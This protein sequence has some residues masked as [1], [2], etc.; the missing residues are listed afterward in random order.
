[1]SFPRLWRR[2]H[3]E[4][5]FFVVKPAWVGAAGAVLLAFTILRNL[6]FARAHGLT[7]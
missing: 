6:P 7:P 1:M 2:L 3:N 5:F 4:P